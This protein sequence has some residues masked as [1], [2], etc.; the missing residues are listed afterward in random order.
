MV[1]HDLRSPLS[2]VVSI[3]DSIRD[4]LFGPV[5]EPQRKWLWKVEES[6][7]SLIG[8]VSDFL[9]MSKIDAGKLQLLKAPVDLA[10]LLRDRLLEYSLEADKRK[11]AL[12][13]SISDSFPPLFLDGRRFNQVLDNL[14][15]NAFKFTD[16][17]GVVE[18]AAQ[19]YGDRDVV[20]WVKD[21]GIGIAD[22]ETDLIF[23]KYRQVIS[24]QQADRKGTG[25]GL[26]ICKKIVEAHGGR[27]W[28]ESVPGKGST[29]FVSLPLNATDPGYALPA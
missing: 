16:A 20:M 12:K 27:I 26:A 1:A 5:T 6:C 8:H 10:T 14:L 21:S 11:I 28:V 3:T 17:G 23:D 22:D 15:S 24:G 18:V 13:A 19:I 2:N 29:F 25:L 9:D 7:R 4:G